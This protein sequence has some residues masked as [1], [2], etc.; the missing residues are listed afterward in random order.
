M[1][2]KMKEYAKLEDIFA[3]GIFTPYD[4]LVIWAKRGKGKSAFA[5]FLQTEFMRPAI[6]DFF[7]SKSKEK[8]EKLKRAGIYVEPPSDHLVF[9]DTFCFDYRN[10]NRIAYS[11]KATEIGIPNKIHKVKQLI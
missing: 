8:C 10:P 7:I 6:A 3:D 2:G 4:T 11:I 9:N 1:L 5:A